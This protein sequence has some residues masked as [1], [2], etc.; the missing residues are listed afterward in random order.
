[1][2]ELLRSTVDM[3]KY[4]SARNI[5]RIPAIIAGI[6]FAIFYMFFTGIIITSEIPIPPEVPVPYFRVYTTLT[7]I[8]SIGVVPWIIAYLNR[9]T[10][11]SMNF[12]AMLSTVFISTL[13]AI[14]VALLLYRRYLMKNYSC[15]CNSGTPAFAGV[16]PAFFSVFACCGGGLLLTIFGPLFF[17]S[18]QGL[19][20]YFS[21]IS[22]LA[23]LAGVFVTVRGIKP[24]HLQ[25][26]QRYKIVD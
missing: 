26:K 7:G 4:V 20:G 19:G 12:S 15:N 17:L 8:E 21:A 11:F 23:L 6:V 16:I 14:N 9:H 13:I 2:N 1:M 24:I 10:V 3:I 18:L 5:Y 22:I 25:H